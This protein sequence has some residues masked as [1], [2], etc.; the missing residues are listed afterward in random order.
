MKVNHNTQIEYDTKK[1]LIEYCTT[2]GMSIAQA[3]EEA[4]REYL[5]KKKKSSK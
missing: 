3:T 2:K 1:A 5:E 4:I